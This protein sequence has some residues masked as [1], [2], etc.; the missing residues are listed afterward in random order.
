ME[1]YHHVVIPAEEVVDAPALR[2]VNDVAVVQGVITMTITIMMADAMATV[3]GGEGIIIEDDHVPILRED[4]HAP[5][6]RDT[7]TDAAVEEMGGDT[8]VVAMAATMTIG[9]M[10]TTTATVAVVDIM[11]A[12]DHIEDRRQHLRIEPRR[13]LPNDMRS[14]PCYVNFCGRRSWRRSRPS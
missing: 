11:V 7:K 9:G 8:A 5:I 12:V 2:E 13:M 4:D 14:S 3:V 6:L 1:N 10:I